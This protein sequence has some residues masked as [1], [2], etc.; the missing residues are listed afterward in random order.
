VIYVPAS[1][2]SSTCAICGSR[3]TECSGRRVW[4]PQCRTLED[5]DVN[6]ARYIVARGLRFGPVALPVEAM[7]REP[8]KAIP[9][10]D[11]SG[12]TQGA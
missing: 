10:V 11:E 3:I 9:K 1:K 6:A 7:V 12:L 2:T 5:R 4:Y 8:P